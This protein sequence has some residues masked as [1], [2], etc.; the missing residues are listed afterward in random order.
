M[1]HYNHRAKEKA[2]KKACAHL[3][4]DALNSVW[5]AVATIMTIT[6]DI[7]GRKIN[8]RVKYGEG[9]YDAIDD[10]DIAVRMVDYLDMRR[11]MYAKKY[12]PYRPFGWWFY[13]RFVRIVRGKRWV[14][15]KQRQWQ[16]R[17]DASEFNGLVS[18]NLA[19]GANQYLASPGDLISMLDRCAHNGGERASAAVLMMF[20]MME[21]V[22]I[23]QDR[24]GANYAAV[25]AV[26]ATCDFD[27]AAGGVINALL[28]AKEMKKKGEDKREKYREAVFGEIY[29][30]LAAS[31]EE[32]ST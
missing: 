24:V 7:K 32:Q 16:I 3:V 2:Y 19:K 10:I 25:A 11:R 21:R 5:D 29:N 23:K 8:Y 22:I 28:V 31:I 15:W 17:E 12:V 1:Q 26:R 6:A 18:R 14:G 30:H 9:L 20:Y 27:A 4:D 13:L